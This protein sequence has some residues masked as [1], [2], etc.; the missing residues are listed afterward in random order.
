MGGKGREMQVWHSESS[1]RECSGQVYRGESSGQKSSGQVYGDVNDNDNDMNHSFSQ[2]HVH[3]ALTCPKGQ[4]AGAVTPPWLSKDIRSMHRI[5]DQSE[6]LP[7][8]TKWSCICAGK[9]TCYAQCECVMRNPDCCFVAQVCL[10]W[11]L[12]CYRCSTVGDLSVGTGSEGQVW[13]SGRC[14][15]CLAERD[16]L[17]VRRGREGGWS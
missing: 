14:W 11:L 2:L 6:L 17:M 10:M 9:E 7:F 1:G 15:G 4:S 13:W 8:E 3:K 16:E 12:R 5:N